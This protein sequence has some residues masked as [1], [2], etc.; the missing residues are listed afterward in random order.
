M[1]HPRGERRSAGP[2][3][4]SPG[5]RLDVEGAIHYQDPMAVNSLT[6]WMSTVFARAEPGGQKPEDYFA[7]RLVEADRQLQALATRLGGVYERGA[8]SW[9]AWAV[10]PGAAA[11]GAAAAL[12]GLGST[13]TKRL[14]GLEIE[15][16]VGV[17][18]LATGE[19]GEGASSR[20]LVLV[21]GVT[22]AAGPRSAPLLFNR[23]DAAWSADEE[24]VTGAD[25]LRD[26]LTR[27][28]APRVVPAPPSPMPPAV[29][30]ARDRVT[31]VAS[32]VICAESHV[33]VI[34]RPVPRK[35]GEPRHFGQGSF[36]VDAV[37]DL[38][39]RSRAFAHAIATG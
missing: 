13:V 29:T 1:A 12:W 17:Q 39:E 35:P 8:V 14:H 16:T 24:M 4:P 33:L 32:K 28:A 9:S 18:P 7:P 36:E 22:V 10:A 37:F 30:N 19:R 25:R 15:V 20:W 27:G 6:Q 38:V 21:P 2:G 31:R 3:N 23:Y 26:L 5:R 11:P 34:G